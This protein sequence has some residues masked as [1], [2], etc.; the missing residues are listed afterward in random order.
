M[1][2]IFSIKTQLESINNTSDAY[3]GLF[4]TIIYSIAAFFIVFFSYWINGLRKIQ[5]ID[6]VL[7]VLNSPI[8]VF[9]IILITSK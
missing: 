3:M 4:L 7:I 1:M 8:I 9:L 2:I 6:V 5:A